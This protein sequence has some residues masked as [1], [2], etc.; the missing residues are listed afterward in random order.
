[1]L[2]EPIE[3]PC[4]VILSNRVAKGAMTEGLADRYD[5]PTVSHEQLYRTWSV[6]G[7]GLHITGNVMVDRRF[8]ERPGNVVCDPDTDRDAL[9]RWATAGTVG[10][11]HLWMQINHP[12]RQCQR[13]SSSQPLAPSEVGLKMAGLFGTP[14][15]MTEAEILDAIARWARTAKMAQE[16]GF[17]GVQVH[18]AHGYLSSQFLSPHTNRRTDR[19]GGS[20]ENRARFLLETVRAVREAVGSAFPVAVKLNSSDFRKGGFTTEDAMQVAGWL[21][22]EGIDLLEVS[23][24]TYESVSFITGGT[25]RRS[26]S[27]RKREAYFL[28]YAR[29]I[30]EVVPDVPLMVTGGFRTVE[31]M[32]QALTDGDLDVV[33]IARPFC[34][35]TDLASQILAGAVDRLPVPEAQLSLGGGW[36]G[37]G[38]SNTTI[39]AFNAQAQTAWFYHQILRISEGLSPQVD[40]GA[41]MALARHQVRDL[42]KAVARAR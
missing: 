13:T 37:P 18:S 11:N 41:R 38:S 26:E 7:A 32:Q 10:G 35:V 6:G 40:L 29:Q 27:T 19:W 1:M 39:R 21:G 17:T 36:M 25:D 22:G 14:R 24:G 30:R 12:G 20:L 34:V 4:G 3:L 23:G 8:L 5:N 2:S 28:E 31:V 15:A 9:A 16:A 33:G 42:A